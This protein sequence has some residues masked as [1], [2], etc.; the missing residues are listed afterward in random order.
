MGGDSKSEGR[1]PSKHTGWTF[2]TFICCKNCDVYVDE[3]KWKRPEWPIFLKLCFPIVRRKNIE[4][5]VITSN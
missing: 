3:N 1:I 5:R 2:F 4:V